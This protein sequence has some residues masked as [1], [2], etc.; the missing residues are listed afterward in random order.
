M[1]DER[2]LYVCPCPLLNERADERQM[3]NN[4]HINDG[5]LADVILFYYICLF[6]QCVWSRSIRVNDVYRT[7]LSMY[8]ECCI[9]KLLYTIGMYIER[10]ECV[11]CC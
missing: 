10:E 2:K 1:C 11:W 9:E 4:G 8:T 6:V 5:G 3:I 7:S